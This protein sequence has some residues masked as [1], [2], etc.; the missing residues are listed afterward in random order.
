MAG[1]VTAQGSAVD[2][3]SEITGLLR[4]Y[5]VVVGTCQNIGQRYGRCFAGG[6]RP[7]AVGRWTGVCFGDGQPGRGGK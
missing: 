4:T 3:D 1:F 6:E 5:H 7:Q 2:H